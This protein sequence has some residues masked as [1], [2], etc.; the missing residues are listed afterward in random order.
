MTYSEL[1]QTDSGYRGHRYCRDCGAAID[2]DAPDGT[3]VC[4]RCEAR[5]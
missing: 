4:H 5:P 3:L 2:T 1:S